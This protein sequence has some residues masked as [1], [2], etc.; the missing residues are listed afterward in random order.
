MKLWSSFRDGVLLREGST[1]AV[2]LMRV[3]LGLLIWSRWAMEV[4]PYWKAHPQHWALA[5]VFFPISATLTLG[6]ASQASA[7]LMALVLWTMRMY[8]GYSLGMEEW[9]HHHTNLLV[10][11]TT[12]LALTPCG[13]SFSVDRYL[14][15]RRARARGEALPAE[16]G[17]LWAVS[18]MAVQVSTLYLWSAWD[19]CNAAFL[20]GERL[21]HMYVRWY[22]F[23]YP[24]WPW[25]SPAAQAFA[26]VTIIIEVVLPVGLFVRR[27]QWWL[28]PTGLML[29]GVFYILLPVGTFSLTMALL[30]LAYVDPQVVHRAIDELLGRVDASGGSEPAQR[31]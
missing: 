11:A 21:E 19:K 25:F 14:A 17:P 5:V 26:I 22:F 6:I 18:L 4:A 8:F 12:L 3:G 1:R 27:W 20:S 7:A 2:G 30:Y 24:D 23:D 9:T 10:M 28:I 31:G 13:R 16:S 15:V 29:H